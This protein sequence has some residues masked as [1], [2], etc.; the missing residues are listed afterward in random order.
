[1]SDHT[2]VDEE[3]LA[4]RESLQEF[5]Q[6]AIEDVK[7]DLREDLIE[8]ADEQGY[9]TADNVREEIND[10]FTGTPFEDAFSDAIQQVELRP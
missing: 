4:Q 5:V 6:E 2:H 7:S 1:M 9:L 10:A 3:I 8:Y